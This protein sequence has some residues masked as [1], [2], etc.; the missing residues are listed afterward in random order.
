MRRMRGRGDEKRKEKKNKGRKR[1]NG[2]RM[3]RGGR[4]DEE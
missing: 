2:R 4:G 3:R 1:I